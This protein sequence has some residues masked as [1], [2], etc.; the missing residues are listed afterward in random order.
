[1]DYSKE[2]GYLR[3]KTISGIFWKGMERVC[4]QT[5]STIVSIVIARLLIPEDYSVV[6]IITIF[7]SF[8]NL[9]ISSGL[10]TALVQKKEADMLDYAT[11]MTTSFSIASILYVV[12]FF[13]A[14]SISRL[15]NKPV[16]IPAIRVMGLSFFINAYKSVV[17]A[18][19]TSELKFRMFFWGT[20]IGTVIS[21]IVG[22]VMALKG[23]GPWA[24]IAQQMTNSFIDALILTILLKFK[25]VFK[26]SFSRFKDLFQ[27]GGRI[28]LASIITVIYDQTKPL[29]VGIKYSTQDLAFYNKGQNFPSL[30]TSVA[31]NT[32]SSS[33]FPVMAKVQDDKN[34]ILSM[35]R[36]YIQVASF[37]VFPLMMGFFGV[38][39]NFVRIVLT[40]KWLPIVPYIMIFCFSSMLKPIQDGNL[41]AIRAIGRSDIILKLEIIKKTSY[42]VVI[43]LFVLLTNSPVLLAASGIITSILAS[44]INTR[45]NIKLIGYKMSLQVMDLLPNF[46]TSVIMGFAIYLMNFLNLNL[47]ALTALQIIVGV[48][49]YSILNIII[50]N[51]SFYYLFNTIKGALKNVKNKK[52]V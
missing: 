43:L 18:K 1:M 46:I 33:L 45:P 27:F 29:I 7:F 30:I 2:A 35:T 12:M 32:L 15:Y 48:L 34:A 3:K 20:F 42:F 19:V 52:I 37:L 31:S 24:L 14:P 26:F 36:R 50:K 39:K 9:F 21:A 47:L 8:C 28:F 23:Y 13:T 49:L 5:V 41:Q 51:K 38:S 6:S 11:V 17:C 22:I 44:L 4:A 10:N 40:D 25:I 16:L